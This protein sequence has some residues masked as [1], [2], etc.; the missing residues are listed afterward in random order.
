MKRIWSGLMIVLL[1][2][3]ACTA[4]V[5]PSEPSVPVD[6]TAEQTAPTEEQP[7][8]SEAEQPEPYWEEPLDHL[9]ADDG[10]G[11]LVPY[12][13]REGKAPEG[14]DPTD[15]D[16]YWYGLATTDGRVVTE[17]VY[18]LVEQMWCY[19]GNWE[20]ERIPVYQ[21]WTEKFWESD[22]T[23]LCAVAALDGSWCTE[24]VYLG[25]QAIGPDRLVLADQENRLWF[26]DL[27]GN[28]TPTA[29]DRPITELW[30]NWQPDS[31][32]IHSTVAMQ[33]AVGGNGGWFINLD[34]GTTQYDSETAAGAWIDQG[35]L[36]GASDRDGRCGYLDHEGNW[37][38]PPQYHWADDFYGDYGL[39]RRFGQ[40]VDELIDATG[41]TVLSGEGGVKLVLI[42]S[43]AYWTALDAEGRITEIRDQ[44]LQPVD[45]PAIS[46]Q[47]LYAQNA[48]AWQN[49]DGT[50]Q[51]WDGTTVFDNPD[52]SLILEDCTEDRALYSQSRETGPNWYGLYDT[53]R[54]CW[55]MEPTEGNF[56]LFR[57]NGDTYL[58][59]NTNAEVYDLDGN[60]ICTGDWVG[61]PVNG[62]FPVV[63]GARTGLID[64]SG[65]WVLQMPLD[66]DK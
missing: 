62:V 9:V 66:T 40:N 56:Y 6:S 57:V 22:G 35:V 14:E 38:I 47:F 2:L 15:W 48:L 65:Q 50:R 41:Q 11:K 63:D 49:A 58:G 20:N 17:P 52:S 33:T 29:L 5:E 25:A 34:T 24:A 37:I 27:E 3:T 8:S 26:C 7:A 53:E 46:G 1:L 55:L 59:K 4:P 12:V 19:K 36:L 43:A 54:D 32:N 10:Y 31:M 51:F 42:Q 21:L 60:R 45:L 39:V 18:A 64:R 30:E 13:G 28:I 16:V 23:R 61:I 44:N